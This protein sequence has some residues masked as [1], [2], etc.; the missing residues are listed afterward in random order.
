MA[1]AFPFEQPYWW[2]QF[3]LGAGEESSVAPL[4][5]AARAGDIEAFDQ[6]MR[7]E[8]RCVY[9]TALNLLN[10]PEDAEDAVQQTFLRVYRGLAG[11]DSDRPWR[12]WLYAIAVN[13]C[14]DMGR[15]RRLRAWVSLEAWREAGGEDPVASEPAADAEAELERRR[16]IL[17]QGLK[18]LSPRERE[19]LTLH[20]IEDVPVA[21]AAKILGVAEGT[22][23]SLTSRARAKLSEYVEGRLGG[24]R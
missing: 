14:R 7:L 18:R 5:A 10:R 9:R 6:L 4:V 8:E 21:E 24:R 22:V 15:K 3:S 2:L 19:A 17:Q 11:Y 13:V 16:Q 12:S 1:T 23:R 20:A